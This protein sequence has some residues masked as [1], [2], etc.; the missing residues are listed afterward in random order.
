MAKQSKIPVV[1]C[2][3]IFHK[4]LV[5]LAH[6]DPHNTLLLCHVYLISSSGELFCMLLEGDFLLINPLRSNLP[7]FNYFL[8]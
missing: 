4:I 5:I 6:Y 7:S 2:T 3:H 1:M 8:I